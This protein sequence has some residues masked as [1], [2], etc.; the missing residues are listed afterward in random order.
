MSA[1]S[2]DDDPELAEAIRL[3]LIDSKA[4]QINR[5]AQDV[6]LQQTL[7]LSMSDQAGSSENRAPSEVEEVFPSANEYAEAM[8]QLYQAGLTPTYDLSMS[9]RS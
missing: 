2:G 3:S 4:E 1:E 7:R 6:G 8:A 9:E 5:D